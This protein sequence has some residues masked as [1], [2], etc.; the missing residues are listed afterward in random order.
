MTRA[1]SGQACSTSYATAAEQSNTAAAAAAALPARGKRKGKDAA[2]GTPPPLEPLPPA[3]GFVDICGLELPCRTPDDAALPS[4]ASAAALQQAAAIT[5]KQ[6]Q[7][8]LVRTASMAANLEAAALA[9]CRGRPVL[10]EGPPGCGKT[11]LLQ[12][13][14]RLTGNASDLISIHPDDQMD[15]KSMLG[16]YVCTS[17][18]GEFAWQPGPLAQAVAGGRW[19]VLEDVDMA[20]PDVI[21]ALLPVVET[22]TLHVPSRGQ[23]I[24]AAPGFQLVATVTSTPAS[25]ASAAHGGAHSVRD[26]L[27]GLWSVVRLETPPDGEQLDILT[28]CYPRL[29]PLAPCALAYLH[30][31]QLVT[32]HLPYH[33]PPHCAA[34]EAQLPVWQ[35]QALAA[36]HAAGYAPGELWLHLP[37]HFS[38]RDAFKW[39]ARMD[40]LHGLLLSGG[41]A[42]KRVP[43]GSCDLSGVDLRV[44]EAMFT[45]AA[46]VYAA[47]I[48]KPEARHRLLRAFAV[49][50]ALPEEVVEQQEAREKPALQ[51]TATE[52]HVGRAVLPLQSADGDAAAGLSPP[53][54]AVAPAPPTFA[55]TGHA[56]R[57][58]QRVATALA[59]RE[60]VL[61]VGET[62]TGKTTLVARIAE[63]VGAPLVPFNMSQQTDSSDLL[64]GFKPVDAHDVLLPLVAP[65]L[66]LVRRTWTRGD[67]AEYLSRVSKYAERRKHAQLLGAFKAAVNKVEEAERSTEG[68]S[69]AAV[70]VPTAAATSNGTGH[71]G[72][73]AGNGHRG[74]GDADAAEGPVSNG[75]GGGGSSKKRR[76]VAMGEGLRHEWQLFAG[77]LASA[78]RAAGLSDGGFAFAFVEGK[79]VQAVREGWWLLLDELNLAPP[80]VL[81]RIAGLLEAGGEGSIALLERGDAHQVPRHPRFRLVAA[82]NPATD[83]GKHELPAALRG[84]FTEL[85]VP[86]PSGRDDLRAL[87]A[88]YLAGTGPAPPIDP[89]VDF[90]LAAKAEAVRT[91]LTTSLVSILVC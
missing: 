74:G 77:E 18:P 59:M 40:A 79:L 16:A 28:A 89:I 69:Q 42:L 53:G 71:G 11:L 7:Q 13:L 43:P 8:Q 62:G 36:M 76:K 64:G 82:M 1:A 81:E 66:R 6:T 68:A 54:V 14:A 72:D 83:A 61:L 52:L 60:P 87:V 31:V 4:I 24:H 2:R 65:F 85:W 37:R 15:A 12:E 47:L 90:Y 75:S 38:L 35:L 56:M 78:E 73:A 45:E 88:A 55:R 49:V 70:A 23:T 19:L 10:L 29:S 67:N 84:R 26:L 34:Q 41:A 86:E 91:L 51:V 58:M 80:E 30:T 57:M 20:P 48:A 25:A 5:K 21:A 63:L 44:R 46:D 3:R 17:V 32:G 50:S 39:C 27:G 22:R 9:L 33:G